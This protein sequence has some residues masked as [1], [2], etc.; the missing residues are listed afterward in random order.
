[1]FVERH[2][3]VFDLVQE[4]G[5]D[6]SVAGSLRIEGEKR[7]SSPR[8]ADRYIKTGANP[9]IGRHLTSPVFDMNFNF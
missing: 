9:E 6:V 7:S 1:M 4:R 3:E 8:G 5:Q 2:E